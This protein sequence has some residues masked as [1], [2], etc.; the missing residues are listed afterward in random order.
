MIPLNWQGKVAL[1][2][3]PG[4]KSRS[5]SG[6]RI[7]ALETLVDSKSIEDAGNG[8]NKSICEIGLPIY[9]ARRLETLSCCKK[10]VVV[11]VQW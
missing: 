1:S 8:A 6:F 5:R 3:I 9:L 7:P 4:F 11:R 2:E 10:T